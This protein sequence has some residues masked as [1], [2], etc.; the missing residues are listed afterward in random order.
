MFVTGESTKFEGEC[1]RIYDFNSNNSFEKIQPI[2]SY[3]EH[4]NL[5]TSLVPHPKNDF[6]LFSGSRDCTIKLWDY[7]Q[8]TSAGKKKNSNKLFFKTILLGSLGIFY[9]NVGKVIA[10]EATISCI[11]ACDNIL[12]SSGLDKKLC[13]W[14]IRILENSQPL[15]KISIDDSAILKVAIGPSN[16][17][18]A[19]SSLKGLYLINFNSGL[20]KTVSSFK[21]TCIYHDLKWNSTRNILYAAGDEMIVDQFILT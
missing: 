5:I 17:E 19:I 16:Q 13:I 4:E 1:I 12:I 10:H 15:Q 9:P 21:K 3:G 11:D 6:L 7:R 14:D 2:I 18:A 8:P 20:H